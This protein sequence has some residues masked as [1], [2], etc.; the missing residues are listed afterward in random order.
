MKE[1]LC[2]LKK[3][4]AFILGVISPFKWGVFL[5]FGIAMFSAFDFS[6]RKYLLKSILDIATDQQ[7]H[8]NVISFLLVPVCLYI[9]MSLSVTTVYR[10]YGYVLDIR[11]FPFLKKR[12]ANKC[13]KEILNNDYTYFQDGFTGDLAHKLSNITDGVIELVKLLVDRFFGCCIILIFSIYALSLVSTKFAIATSLWVAIFITISTLYFHVLSSLSNNYSEKNTRVTATVA[14]RLFSINSIKL[15]NNKYYERIKFL[16]SYKEKL[17]SERRLHKA[18]WFLWFVYGYSFDILQIISFYFLISGFSLGKITLGD[19]ALVIGLN[20]ALVE[21]LNQLTNDL[22]RF[23]DH[24]GK[25]LNAL[26]TIFKD[27][28]IKDKDNAKELVVNDGDIIFDKITFSYCSREKLFENLSIHIHPKEKVALV[29]F[30]GAG[31]SSFINLLLRFFD[32]T[33]GKIIIDH[34]SI[35]SVKQDSVR[36]NIAVIPQ[37]LTL[38]HDSILENIRYGKMSATLEEIIKASKLAGI[39]DFIA[40]LPNGYNTL[41]GEKGLKL[42]GGEKQRIHIARAFLKNAPILIL[43]EATNQLDSLTEKEIQA[44]LFKLMYNKTTLVIA[45]RLSTLLHVDRILVLEKGKII[46]EGSHQKL[47][48][49]KGVYQKM[50]NTQTNSILNSEKT[51]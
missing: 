7:G 47:I 50:W 15:F 21:I 43:D 35:T 32:L 30:S 13:Y 31:K 51:I 29:G 20:A 17:I 48:S 40:S 24:Y 33:S 11:I 26:S 25:V 38:F 42:S 2:Q 8:K 6:F 34:Q 49:Q 23:S 16:K 19:F 12:I 3:V 44:S 27:P 18:Y 10:I 37:D 45:H 36:K 4:T 14:D 41:V 46:Q 28:K 5:M 39:H 22:T 1:Q 9:F